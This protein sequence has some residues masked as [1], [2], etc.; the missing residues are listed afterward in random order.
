MDYTYTKGEAIRYIRCCVMNEL[1]RAFA[2]NRDYR[3]VRL[4]ENEIEDF[5]KT[6]YR[7]YRK[8]VDNLITNME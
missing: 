5:S 8:S 4:I 2:Y 7:R 6:S 3:M 1:K